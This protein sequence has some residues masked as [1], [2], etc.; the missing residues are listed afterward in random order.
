VVIWSFLVPDVFGPLHFDVEVQAE[1]FYLLTPS[2]DAIKY[3]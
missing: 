3:Y 1:E 2:I